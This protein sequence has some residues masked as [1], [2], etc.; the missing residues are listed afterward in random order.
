M[1]CGGWRSLT[2]VRDEADWVGRAPPIGEPV[3]QS[4]LVGVLIS[5]LGGAVLGA[6]LYA[7]TKTNPHH[8]LYYANP[9][10]KW[11][12]ADSSN[13]PAVETDEIWQ[14]PATCVRPYFVK[15]T[16]QAK[17]KLKAY[18]DAPPDEI[19]ALRDRADRKKSADK[20][21]F[22]YFL[23]HEQEK[24][25]QSVAGPDYDAQ[26]HAKYTEWYV[27]VSKLEEQAEQWER[28]VS[29]LADNEVKFS[30]TRRWSVDA[31]ASS[32][33]DRDLQ[34]YTLALL[35]LGAFS[36]D[37]QQAIKAA[38]IKI[39][40]IKEIAAKTHYHTEIWR[41]PID[42][43]VTFC[44]GLE[45]ILLGV[46]FGPIATWI[47]TGDV[48]TAWQHARDAAKGLVTTARSA[49]TSLIASISALLQHQKVRTF[50]D[51]A[52]R[53]VHKQAMRLV[54]AGERMG[55]RLI[56]V[57]AQLKDLGTSRI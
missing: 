2:K 48:Q 34:R 46:L 1:G 56:T 14:T 26:L 25:E 16:V 33:T 29:N 47:S 51:Q 10:Y 43:I 45:L 3:V 24:R 57:I 18:N 4:T 30:D 50:K 7:W 12:R 15:A 40:P 28:R 49:L 35:G 53:S 11:V 20:T 55:K 44:L 42:H 17:A 21:P 27:S 23:K 5:L 54:E 8:H 19:R 32:S 22:Y 6:S 36:E 9:E 39:I 13:E 31:R 38:C 52:R 37:Q 41:W